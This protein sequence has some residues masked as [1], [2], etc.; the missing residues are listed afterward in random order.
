MEGRNKDDE[1]WHLVKENRQLRGH[2]AEESKRSERT[3]R[4]FVQMRRQFEKHIES[5]AQSHSAVEANLI[6][7]IANLKL[8]TRRLETEL[9]DARSHIFSLQSYRKDVT[10]DEV[11]QVR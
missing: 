6:D 5:S 10:P 4:H 2:L 11:G 1:L 7:Q 9:E 8:E 3:E